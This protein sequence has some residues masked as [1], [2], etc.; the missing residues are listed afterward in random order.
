MAPPYRGLQGTAT[1]FHLGARKTVATEKGLEWTRA[2]V[3]TNRSGLPVFGRI[4]LHSLRREFRGE[5]L[6]YVFSFSDSAKG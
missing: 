2:N 5:Y 6:S 3:M 4:L 1:M